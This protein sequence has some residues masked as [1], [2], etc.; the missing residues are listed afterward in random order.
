[1][2]AIARTLR[3]TSKK[4]NLIAGLIREKDAVLAMSI[5]KFTPKKAARIL[6]K[7]LKSAVSN[8]ENNF[9]QEPSSLYIKEIIVT[10]GPSLKRS[11]PVSR[12]RVHPIRKRTS[13]ATVILGVREEPAAEKPAKKTEALKATESKPEKAGKK[14]PAVKPSIK[15]AHKKKNITTVKA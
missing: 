7:I 6:G 3:I 9:K 4:L 15:P 2:K 11:V 8:A 14:A 1:M 5:L 10:E 12:G 13:H